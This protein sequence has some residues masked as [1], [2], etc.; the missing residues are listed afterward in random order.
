MG[1]EKTFSAGSILHELVH[2]GVYK[3]SQGRMTRQVTLGVVALTFAYGAWRLSDTLVDAAPLIRYVSIGAVLLVGL[4]L[5]Y[6]LVNIPSFADFLISV[7]AEMNKVSW[8]TWPEL[9]RSTLVVIFV[10][11]TMALLLYA[12]DFFWVALFKALGVLYSL[13]NE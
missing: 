4:W 5:S 8:P 2:F 7:E 9:V 13:P 6:R 10:I 11:V 1:K 12:Y 3:G